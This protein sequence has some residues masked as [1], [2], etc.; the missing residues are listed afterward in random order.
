M[1]LVRLRL[2]EEVNWSDHEGRGCIKEIN[3]VQIPWEVHKTEAEQ[4]ADC[5]QANVSF[6]FS[7]YQT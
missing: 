4:D 1:L 3:A 5:G 2:K 6:S 7:S